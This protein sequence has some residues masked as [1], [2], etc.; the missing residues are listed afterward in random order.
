M[1]GVHASGASLDT[2]EI[3]RMILDAPGEA[4]R[5]AENEALISSGSIEGVAL[6]GKALSKYHDEIRSRAE[7]KGGKTAETILLL[8]LLNDIERL[9]REI[10]EIADIIEATREE[11]IAEYG[12][13]FLEDMAQKFLINGELDELE[14]FSP[15]DRD[16]AIIEALSEKMLDDEG[17]IKPEY[18]GLTIAVHVEALGTYGEKVVQRDADIDQVRALEA[19]NGTD[20][21]AQTDTMMSAV[22]TVM[23]EG[24]SLK[25]NFAQQASGVNS[26]HEMLEI[27]MDAQDSEKIEDVEP[28]RSAFADLNSNGF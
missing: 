22:L 27:A 11:L 4:A 7:R 21:P 19:S 5:S 8:D 13:D 23:D 10:A 28:T 15:E 17:N 20:K 6:R 12:E 3:E 1:F 25:R 14:G 18:E 24:T 9:N 16:A 2:P 26:A